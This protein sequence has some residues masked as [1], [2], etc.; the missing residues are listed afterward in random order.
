M[1]KSILPN[2]YWVKEIEYIHRSAVEVLENDNNEFELEED[3]ATIT[4]GNETL[5]DTQAV[6]INSQEVPVEESLNPDYTN[7]KLKELKLLAKKMGVQVSGNKADYVRA[8]TD[9]G[10]LQ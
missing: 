8:L 2:D 4:H 7:M 3:D 9:L 6:D 1:N 10:D 5:K